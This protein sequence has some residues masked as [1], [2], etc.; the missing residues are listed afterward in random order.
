MTT[1]RLSATVAQKNAAEACTGTKNSSDGL[2][3]KQNQVSP[4]PNHRGHEGTQGDS[5]FFRVPQCA[6]WLKIL[7]L[8]SHH[9]MLQA[10]HGAHV[11]RALEGTRIRTTHLT[12]AAPSSPQCRAPYGAVD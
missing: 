8:S 9:H 7:T 12:R 11:L 3:K 4:R 1:T 6:L 10:L 2:R 5:R